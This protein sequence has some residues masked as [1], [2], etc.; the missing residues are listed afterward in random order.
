MD[1]KSISMRWKCNLGLACDTVQ[2]TLSIQRMLV[3]MQT[4]D[5]QRW[6]EESKV[7]LESSF[8]MEWL[9]EFD[10]IKWVSKMLVIQESK[11]EHNNISK[12]TLCT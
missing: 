6:T 5:F 12:K 7:E 4:S 3:S 11:W 10:F 1:D 8:L 2:G 9:K